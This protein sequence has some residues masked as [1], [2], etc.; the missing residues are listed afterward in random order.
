MNNISDITMLIA[1]LALALWPAAIIFMSKKVE[2]KILS[3][4]KESYNQEKQEK[5]INTENLVI[6]SLKKL[7]CNPKKNEN[8]NLEFMYQGDDFYISIQEDTPFIMIWY[9][10]WGTINTD[11]P[12]LPYLK[13]VINVVNISSFV[14]TV[15]MSENEGDQ[16]IG[17][18]SHCHT[19]LTESGMEPEEHLRM[20]LES[21]FETRD[22]IK[23]SINKLGSQLSDE[24]EEEKKKRVIVKGFSSYKDNSTPIEKEKS[25]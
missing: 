4:L 9:P 7:G 24:S 13:E 8:G 12:V 5:E 20:L 15:C 21:F 19:F 2:K 25:K 1:V 18:H 3:S 16:E 17:I 11:N 10:W 23:D 6:Q 14:T 22:T